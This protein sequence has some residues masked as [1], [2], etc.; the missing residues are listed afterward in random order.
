MVNFDCEYFPGASVN[1]ISRELARLLR[2]SRKYSAIFVICGICSITRKRY[3]GRI[4]LR[5]Y[6][7]DAAVNRVIDDF[8]S[9]I[10]NARDYTSI[11][12]IICPTM[13][14]DLMR[15]SSRDWFSFKDQPVLDEVVNKINLHIRGINRLNGLTTP[16]LSSKTHR[17]SGH[18]GKYRSHYGH[19]WDG[20]HPSFS[21]RSWWERKIV[22]YFLRIPASS[23]HV[24]RN[25]VNHY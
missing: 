8:Y 5:E 18:R 2:H 11:P 12:I 10:A 21:L 6:N 25:Q 24:P 23:Y 19:L 7:I 1:T 20:C 9:L 16:D 15:Y 22:E 17:C 13:G 4:L 3:D 14:I